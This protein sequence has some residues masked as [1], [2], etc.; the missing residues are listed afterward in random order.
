MHHRSLCQTSAFWYS[1]SHFALSIS[2]STDQKTCWVQQANFHALA[3]CTSFSLLVPRATARPSWRRFKRTWAASRPGTGARPGSRRA[4]RRWR[5]S[6]RSCSLSSPGRS[7][8]RACVAQ[9]CCLSCRV[10]SAFYPFEVGTFWIANN[11]D[12]CAGKKVTRKQICS[13]LVLLRIANTTHR[14]GSDSFEEFQ[15]VYGR[16][17]RNPWGQE[18]STVFRKEFHHTLPGSHMRERQHFDL[19]RVANFCLVLAQVW[20]WS[21]RCGISRRGGTYSMTPWRGRHPRTSRRSAGTWTQRRKANC[22]KMWRRT[23][24]KCERQVTTRFWCHKRGDIDWYFLKSL[25]ERV[26][27]TLCLTHTLQ[28]MLLS[29]CPLI[30]MPLQTCR[31][32]RKKSVQMWTEWTFIFS[33]ISHGLRARG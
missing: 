4:C 14:K 5:C 17:L 20:S 15:T 28:V 32:E 8:V 21:C 1:V 13:V 18:S 22:S 7:Q 12:V 16:K 30:W 25:S 27:I 23:T 10:K 6:S 19:Y 2:I 9:F 11:A 33:K 29:S 31:G 24:R 3:A 26:Y